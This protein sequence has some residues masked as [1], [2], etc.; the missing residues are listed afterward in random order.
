[1]EGIPTRPW[2]PALTKPVLFEFNPHYEKE[3]GIAESQEQ[4]YLFPSSQGQMVTHP[5]WKGP[6]VPQRTGSSHLYLESPSF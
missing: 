2:S 3:G 1:M 4:T 6:V 5:S